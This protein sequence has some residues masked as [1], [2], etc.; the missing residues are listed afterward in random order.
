[1]GK[2]LDVVTDIDKKK[3]YNLSE[4]H[5]NNL[6]NKSSTDFYN[7]KKSDNNNFYIISEFDYSK[8][9]PSGKISNGKLYLTEEEMKYLC[10]VNLIKFESNDNNNE[11]NFNSESKISMINKMNNYILYGYL[12]RAGKVV[13]WY[14]YYSFIYLSK[15]Y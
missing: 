10:D 1:M 8:F 11:N 9:H 2:E 12:K 5:E 3:G 15:F 13:I 4:I 6:N 7:C 14:V